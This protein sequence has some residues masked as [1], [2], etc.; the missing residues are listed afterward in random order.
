MRASDSTTND[1]S[2]SMSRSTPGKTYIA[3]PAPPA[4]PSSQQP[5]VA[6]TLSSASPSRRMIYRD[7]IFDVTITVSGTSALYTGTMNLTLSQGITHQTLGSR[8]SIQMYD[9]ASG[10]S[11]PFCTGDTSITSLTFTAADNGV[12]TFKAVINIAQIVKIKAIDSQDSSISS[13]TPEIHI[14]E[15]LRQY[16][17]KYTNDT[18]N[19]YDKNIKKWI[20]YWEDWKIGDPAYTFMTGAIP[21]GELVKAIAYKESSLSTT[22]GAGQDLMQMT[23]VALN[24][25][26]DGHDNVRRDI[27]A[28]LIPSGYDGE[29]LSM[30]AAP[31]MNYETPTDNTVDNSF[32]WGIRWLIDKRTDYQYDRTRNQVHNIRIID[33]WGANGAVKRYGDPN[34]PTYVEDVQKL[35]EEGRNPNRN[36]PTYLWPIKADG[37]PRQ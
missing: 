10:A 11:N 17:T 24:S 2:N 36:N 30:D 12:K 37:C 25:M 28:R 19:D 13:E 1:R 4:P 7:E 16:T 34:N 33:W 6:L 27:N 9:F 29:H 20:D 5:T 21:D 3:P 35:Y 26:T 32:K 18:V 14:V 31:F 15:R 23:P 8:G 22:K